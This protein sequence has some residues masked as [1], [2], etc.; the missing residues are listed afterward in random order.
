MQGGFYM[1]R[2]KKV[3][4]SKYLHFIRRQGGDGCWGC[5]HAT[6]WD[7][8]N[9]KVCPYTPDLSNNLHLWLHRRRFLWDW[10]AIDETTGAKTYRD[11]PGILSPDGRFHKVK[12]EPDGLLHRQQI[13]PE[14]GIFQSLGNV[15][16]GTERTNPTS[17]WIGN[18]TK[19]G[20]NEAHN[21]RMKTKLIPV[22][23]SIDAFQERLSLGYPIRVEGGKKFSG[24]VV[25]VIGYDSGNNR[26]T[27][28]DSGVGG[29]GIFTFTFD[30][31]EDGAVEDAYYFE[32]LPPKPVP[33]AR[34]RIQHS[35]RMNISLWLSVSDS[36]LP[37]RKI[38]NSDD[39]DDGR[40][41]LW[42]T[43]RAPS[44]MIWP[45]SN[46]SRLVL[47]IHDS[48]TFSN[49]GGNVI[50]FTAAFGGRI[51]KCPTLSTGPAQIKPYSHLQLTIP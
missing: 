18:W 46:S 45:P 6:V 40:G 32:I 25:A 1:T 38:W 7:I 10:S 39:W 44:E 27:Y 13:G 43:V 11:K 26:F 14:F 21:Y 42:Y 50:E 19:E 48:A 5:A 29:K 4:L 2:P 28:V 16:E 41:D 24:H 8:M 20:V 3:D 9:E 51:L 15:T 30:E 22:E 49:D 37:K 34:I 12:I 35:K 31:L 23:I 33:A 17:R 47:D 36:P